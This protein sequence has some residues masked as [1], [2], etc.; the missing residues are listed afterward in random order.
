[1]TMDDTHPAL[2]YAA[3]HGID[4]QVA[5]QIA[6]IAVSHEQG[7]RHQATPEDIERARELYGSDT[8]NIDDDA[9]VSEYDD[10]VWVQAWVD[11]EDE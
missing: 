6:E 4:L 3:E 7:G 10:G 11:L 1:M 8:V 5:R 2:R 9:L